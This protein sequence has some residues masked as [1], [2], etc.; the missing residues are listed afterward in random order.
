MSQ[1]KKRP[2]KSRRSLVRDLLEKAGSKGVLNTELTKI[3]TRFTSSLYVLK[4]KGYIIETKFEGNGVYRYTLIGK[5]EPS[6]QLSAFDVLAKAIE[7]HDG[8]VTKEQLH[9]IM[10][11]NNL[12]FKHK[13]KKGDK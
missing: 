12:I 3:S 8:I 9:A 11:E 10:S 1:T 7:E 6:K 13:I 2:Y 4:K 5:Q